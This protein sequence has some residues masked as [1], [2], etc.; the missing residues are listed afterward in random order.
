MI[1]ADT[2]VIAYL[3]LPGE[4][5]EQARQALRKDQS[6][7]APWLWRSEFRNALILYVRKRWIMLSEAQ[8]MLD[9]SLRLM[10][11]REHDVISSHVL[12]LATQSA[13]SAYD[14]EFV[15]LAQDL[16]VPLVTVDKQVLAEFPEVAISLD[17]YVAA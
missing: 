15:A 13:C 12:R 11:G 14:C 6:W 3:Y 17:E 7:A 16:N 9:E 5:L 8:E 1:V 4:R 2:N 10:F